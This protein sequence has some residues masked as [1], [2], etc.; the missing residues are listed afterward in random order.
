[1]ASTSALVLPPAKHL[2]TF[3]GAPTTNKAVVAEKK[4]SL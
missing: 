3:I 2:V 4:Q 1:M